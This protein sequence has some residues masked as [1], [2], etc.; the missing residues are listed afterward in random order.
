M[1]CITCKNGETHEGR[2]TMSIDRGSVVVV[3]RDVPAQVCTTCGEEYLDTEI[4]K[5]IETIVDHAQASGIDV[6]VQH[7]TA[8]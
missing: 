2:V 8:A 6:S 5:K 1:R 4:I 7:F 3:V